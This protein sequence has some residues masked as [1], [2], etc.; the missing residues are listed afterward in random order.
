MTWWKE[1]LVKLHEEY[2]AGTRKVLET[3]S[4][5][6]LYGG[7]PF[8]ALDSFLG[9][10]RVLRQSFPLITRRLLA[11]HQLGPD[12]NVP[13]GIDLFLRIRIEENEV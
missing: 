3:T 4:T 5:G 6:L 2:V 7:A 10:N 9:P 13:V 12:A 11:S 1:V 8:T